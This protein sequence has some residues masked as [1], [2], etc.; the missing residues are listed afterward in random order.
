MLYR[1]FLVDMCPEVAVRYPAFEV[2]TQV[3]KALEKGGLDSLYLVEI[4]DGLIIHRFHH[5]LGKVSSCVALAEFAMYSAYISTL[6]YIDAR[7]GRSAASVL[8]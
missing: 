8:W 4:R 7:E 6:L 3:E 2:R 5:Y 1:K